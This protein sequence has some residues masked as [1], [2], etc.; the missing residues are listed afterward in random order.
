M[1][2][3]SEDHRKSAHRS[4][5]TLKGSQQ[6]KRPMVAA[7]GDPAGVGA[8]APFLPNVLDHSVVAD[9]RHRKFWRALLQIFISS[10]FTP[11]CRCP[12]AVHSLREVSVAG[13]DDFSHSFL[14]SW[15]A[16][17][18]KIW[19]IPKLGDTGMRTPKRGQ[20]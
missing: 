12:F 14:D 17:R 9:K 16:K 3:R 15:D 18:E 8:T 5:P 19:T 7:C 6:L 11:F 4:R 13:S 2:E 10:F 1:V 20:C